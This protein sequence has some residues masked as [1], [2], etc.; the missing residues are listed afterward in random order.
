[1]GSFSM[2]SELAAWGAIGLVVAITFASR[3]AGGLLMRFVNLS[4]KL[5][6]FLQAVS[7][8]VVA[9]LVASLLAQNGLREAVA[10]AV[11]SL[12]MAT[13]KSPVA[14]MIVGMSVAGI[15]TTTT[16]T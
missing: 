12:A 2:P 7:V 8:S 6:I 16:L 11:A 4:P 1:L 3:I 13:F 14:A 15:W 5:E 10:V 9:A